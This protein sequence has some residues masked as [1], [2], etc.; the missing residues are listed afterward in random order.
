[1]WHIGNTISGRN[2]PEIERLMAGNRSDK[3]S[4]A[5]ASMSP[6]QI[7]PLKSSL[8][9]LLKRSPGLRRAATRL[10]DGLFGLLYEEL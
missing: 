7:K 1:V 3:I 4:P 6:R 5:A 10:Y 9:S 2:V 8:H